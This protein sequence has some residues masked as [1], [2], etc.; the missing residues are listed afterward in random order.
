MI[1]DN[2]KIVQALHEVPDP[3]GGSN[4]IDTGRVRELK[5]QEN[6]IF[7]QLVVNGLDAAEKAELHMSSLQKINS[8]YPEAEVD[9]HMVQEQEGSSQ[10]KILPQVK[11]VIAVA[12]GKG[13]VGKSTVTANLARALKK[14]GVKVGVLDGDLY[15]PSMPILFGMEGE[16]PE[17]VNRGPSPKL[18]PLRTDEDIPI[19]SLG[20]IISPEQAVVLRG[21]RLAGLIKQFIED[22][23]WPELDVLLID[24]P[25]GTGDIQLT[26]VQTVPVTGAIIVTTPQQLSY[27][28]ALKAL[29]MFKMDSISV[30]ILGIVE[31]MAWFTPE[32]LPDRKYYLFGEGG[33]Q[34]LADKT[35]NVLIGQLPLIAGL[36]AASDDPNSYNQSWSQSEGYF[37]RLAEKTMEQLK[38]RNEKMAPTDV[39]RITTQ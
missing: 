8:I 28:D 32:D 35:D 12:S 21:P 18:L 29:N 11:N 23:I 5:I 39:V 36:R 33:G 19:I 22:C 7:F 25:P 6:R 27:A 17:V 10:M 15:G 31:N 26:L 3:K 2:N 37:G 38:I 14:Q 9:V 24:L 4:I 30:P 20:F 16:K 1:I 34:K 13:G